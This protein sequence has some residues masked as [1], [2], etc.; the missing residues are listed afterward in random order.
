M[1]AEPGR[2]VRFIADFEQGLPEGTRIKEFQ[3]QTRYDLVPGPN[4]TVLQAQSQG[5]ASGLIFPTEFSP[6][7]YPRLQWRWKVAHVLATGDAR[8]KATDDYAARVYVIFP[9]WLP[10]RIRSINYIWANRLP[11]GEAMANTYTANARMIAVRSGDKDCGRWVV[12][13]RNILE[14]YRWLFGEE[15]PQKAVISIMTDTDQ[16]GEEAL[17]WYDDI[18]ISR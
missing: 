4:G 14:D 10:L 18:R 8:A 12:E 2:D 7:E 16:T 17:A 11:Q 1:V 13:E 3:G 15:P 5:Q 6:Y 9:H